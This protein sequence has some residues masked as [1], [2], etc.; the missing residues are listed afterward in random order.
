MKLEGSAVVP[1]S[2]KFSLNAFIFGN[3]GRDVA[4]KF[5]HR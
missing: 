3:R 4:V 2:G 1:C 5:L